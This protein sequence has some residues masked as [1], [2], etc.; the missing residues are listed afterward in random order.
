MASRNYLMFYAWLL[1]LLVINQVIII[2]C[3]ETSSFLSNAT[4][5]TPELRTAYSTAKENLINHTY[6]AYFLDIS[7]IGP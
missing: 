5:E 2:V 7:D 3:G 6:K 1:I 4:V